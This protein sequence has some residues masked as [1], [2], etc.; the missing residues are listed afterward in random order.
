MSCCLRLCFAELDARLRPGSL[1]S[2][3]TSQIHNFDIKHQLTFTAA[4]L[5]GEQNTAGLNDI[6]KEGA[7]KDTLG[8]SVAGLSIMA[9]GM[10]SW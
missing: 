3:E 8:V 6:G 4:L 1:K 2:R 10:A 5:S 7:R 9:G